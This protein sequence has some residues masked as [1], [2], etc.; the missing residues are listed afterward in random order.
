MEIIG[1][2][3]EKYIGSRVTGHNCNF[4]ST[5]TTFDK[6]II[7]AILENGQKV[8]II[9]KHTEGECGSGWSTA[10]WGHINIVNVEKFNGYTFIPKKPI[11][12]K[13]IDQSADD[14][15][16]S[17][18]SVS[19]DGG[20]G[21]YPNGGY[22]VNMELFTETIRHKDIRPVWIFQGD[23]NLGKSFLASRL[24]DLDVYETDISDT[25]PNEITTS[26]IVLGNKYKFSVEDIKGK[27]FG[28]FQVHTVNFTL[29]ENTKQSEDG[30]VV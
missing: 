30:L 26:V 7:C 4:T 15:S 21:Y 18:F 17:V 9:L 24:K 3:I 8:E 22:S 23:S 16:N 10:S 11:I 12:I 28:K 19:D 14:V 25:L 29:D 13:D 2:R 27:I 1:L 6:H 5:K 20:C